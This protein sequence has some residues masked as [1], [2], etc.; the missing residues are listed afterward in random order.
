[1][2]WAHVEA[3]LYPSNKAAIFENP[4]LRYITQVHE[5]LVDLGKPQAPMTSDDVLVGRKRREVDE[6]P[7]KAKKTSN[8]PEFKSD[9]PKRH[10]RIPGEYF[11]KIPKDVPLPTATSDDDE[12]YEP[13]TDEGDD[14]L[15]VLSA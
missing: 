13:S 15:S 3:A 1:M 5:A 4:R 6:H 2:S 14:S 10:V 12:D 7:K 9:R 11:Y 8:V